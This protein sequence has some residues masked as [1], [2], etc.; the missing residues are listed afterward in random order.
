MRYE[1]DFM[2]RAEDPEFLSDI[3]LLR[4][5]W[6]LD[7]KSFL[8]I[9]DWFKDDIWL[10]RSFNS[11]SRSKTI[12]ENRFNVG[13]YYVAREGKKRII[14]GKDINEYL[15]DITE[16]VSKRKW[17]KRYTDFIH[18]LILYGEV[19][20]QHDKIE[21]IIKSDPFIEPNELY[22]KISPDA[23]M[24]DIKKIWPT[25]REILGTYYKK[26]DKRTQ[27]IQRRNFVKNVVGSKLKGKKPDVMKLHEMLGTI[28]DAR[29]GK[30]II[31]NTR[32][33]YMKKLKRTA[34]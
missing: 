31:R 9:R 1:E 21:I 16:L 26:G 15:D 19:K 4:K 2:L 24:K 33:R 22:L 34:S 30:R 6:S 11:K 32:S 25:V 23:R 14:S 7:S 5:K 10:V 12:I 18:E 20:Q 13:K 8:T 17:P 27:P 28:Y 29:K 3:V